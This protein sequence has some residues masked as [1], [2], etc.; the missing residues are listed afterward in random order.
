MKTIAYWHD[1]NGNIGD[2]MTVMGCHGVVNDA[3][4]VHYPIS[5]C[6]RLSEAMKTVVLPEI[7]VAVVCGGPWLWDNCVSSAKYDMLR[8]FIEHIKA[9][10][11][12]ALGIGAS[13]VITEPKP[14]TALESADFWRQFDFV[15]CRD[16]LAAELLRGPHV[17]LWPCPSYFIGEMLRPVVDHINDSV[18]VYT[19]L[20]NNRS[21]PT[22]IYAKPELV[23]AYLKFQEQWV[24]DGKPTVTLTWIDR[25]AFTEKYGREPEIHAGSP[26]RAARTLAKFKNIYT[27]RVHAAVFAASLK[28][29]SH[30][31]AVD[32]RALTAYH[33]GVKP[34]MCQHP[35]MPG[36]DL[37]SLSFQQLANRLRVIFNTEKQ[38]RGAEAPILIVVSTYNRKDL[39]GQTLDSI[40]RN[41]SDL[42]DVLILDDSSTDYD[43]NWLKQWGWKVVRNPVNVGVGEMARKRFEEFLNRGYTY[44]CAIDNDLQLGAHFDYRLLRVW[45]KTRAEDLT[46]VTGYRSKTQVCLESHPEWDVVNSVGGAMQFI[47]R[48]TAQTIMAKMENQWTHN[49]DHRISLLCQRKIATRPSL[50]QHMGIYGSGVN[51]PSTDV[52]I[53]FAGDG[54]W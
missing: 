38:V 28:I 44:L 3:I 47:D 2:T 48:Y 23:A 40:A 41:K 49:W 24:H 20:D 19:A 43:E 42:S 10:V 14:V 54:Q 9:P 27:A 35:E 5:Y 45:Q 29:N 37:R 1:D 51:G 36:A 12:I 30:L 17:D 39:T 4:G 34:F 16:A 31:F 15:A 26:N 53:D 52:A 13:Y 22:A 33:L 25:V 6:S 46:V 21:V 11:K 32:S 18:L 7:D 50:A 8:N